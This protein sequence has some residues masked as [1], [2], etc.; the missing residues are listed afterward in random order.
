M[1][2]WFGIDEQT[3]LLQCEMCIVINHG[4]YFLLF[5]DCDLVLVHAEV[6]V[7]FKQLQGLFMG[8]IR[9]HYGQWDLNSFVAVLFLVCQ[10]IVAVVVHKSFSGQ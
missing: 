3:I 8:V 7:F 4:R 9:S 1:S 5:H 2:M 10:D 6:V